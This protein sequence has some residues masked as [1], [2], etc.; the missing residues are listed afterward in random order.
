MAGELLLKS[1]MAA[2]STGQRTSSRVRVRQL[3]TGLVEP[4]QLFSLLNGRDLIVAGRKWRIEIYSICDWAG[5]RWIQLAVDGMPRRMLALRLAT[6]DGARDA[7]RALSS[8]LARPSDER[9]VLS[10]ASMPPRQGPKRRTVRGDDRPA[11]VSD[12]ATSN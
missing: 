7:V 6:G 4:D 8:W 9:H 10:V 2:K 1:L 3:P 12:L 5:L 11:V